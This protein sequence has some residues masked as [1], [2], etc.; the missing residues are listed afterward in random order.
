MRLLRRVGQAWSWLRLTRYRARARK[1]ALDE[2][3]Y[4]DREA[5]HAAGIYERPGGHGGFG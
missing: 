1:L 5:R 2:Q 3:R 4:Q